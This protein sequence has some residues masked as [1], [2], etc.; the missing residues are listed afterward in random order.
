MF[1][2]SGNARNEARNDCLRRHGSLLAL[3]LLSVGV[4]ARD[5]FSAFPT[6][7]LVFTVARALANSF[8]A[9]GSVL[10]RDPAPIR[11]LFP[12]GIVS[13]GI[14]RQTPSRVSKKSL[15]RK[16]SRSPR[17][18]SPALFAMQLFL[19]GG[20]GCLQEGAERMALRQLRCNGDRML[21]SNTLNYCAGRES[22]TSTPGPHTRVINRGRSLTISPLPV[23]TSQS[24]LSGASSETCSSA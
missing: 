19:H 14:K 5:V 1:P 12:L 9:T 4:S 22:S 24:F 11:R 10:E 6:S 13:G 20:L 17:R 3:Q 2:F 8:C 7:R 23:E 16:D 18:L 15:F 21:N